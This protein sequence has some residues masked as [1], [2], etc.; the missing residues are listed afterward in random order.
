MDAA[1]SH[2]EELASTANEETRRELRLKLLN[3]AYSLEDVNDT[4]HRFAH[5]HLSS[6][7][8]KIGLDLGLFKSLVESKDGVTLESIATRTGADISLLGRLM[9]YLARVGAV[10]QVSQN[11]FAAN[12]T[13]R[14]L[15]HKSSESG[16]AHCFEVVAPIYQA[17]PAFLQKMNYAT[18]LDPV[19]TAWQRA[20]N[21]PMHAME[22]L[23]QHPDKMARFGEY[24]ASRDGPSRGWLDVY[25]VQEELAITHLKE[26]TDRAVFVNVGVGFGHPCAEFKSRFPG[27]HGRVVLQ[28]QPSIIGQMPQ[29]PGVENMVHNLFDEQPIEGAKFYFMRGILHNHPDHLAK[30]ILERVKDAM[31]PDSI[32]LLDDYVVSEK[33]PDFFSRSISDLTMLGTF[34][35]QERFEEQWRSLFDSVGLRLAK[36]YPLNDPP[37]SETVMEVRLE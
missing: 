36:T 26:D 32:L 18:P 29:I 33:L 23:G 11:Q 6:A 9:R 24:M 12:H 13:T 5:C 28:D 21:T 14:N 35:S 25:P 15:S 17:M 34:S 27:V 30:I 22:W 2:I 37:T 31:A 1:I 7:V 8:V 20:F 19:D 16:L 3:I 4:F 10:D